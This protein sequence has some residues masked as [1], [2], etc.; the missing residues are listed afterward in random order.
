MSIFN[1]FSLCGGLAFFLFGMRIMSTG[2]EKMAG[3]RLESTLKTM[4]ASPL[5]SMVLGAGITVAIQS[6]SALTVM[7]VGLVNS[8]IMQLRQTVSVI[9]G[10]NIGTTLTA[11][12]LSLAGIESDNFFIKML[13]PTSFSPLVALVGI[14]LIM[15]SKSDKKKDIGS[16][17]VGFAILM[18][19]MSEMSSS[20]S[21]LADIPEFAQVLT[22]FDNPLMG[23]LI[24]AVVT[25]I[26]QASA[27]SV[28]MLQAL[29]MTGSISIGMAVPIIMGQNIGTCVTAMISSVGTNRNAK[30]VAAVHIFFNIIGTAIFL[31]LFMLYTNFVNPMIADL[32]ITP[33]GIAAAHSAFNV[34]A[35]IVLFPFGRLLE[36]LACLV[37]RDKKNKTE[38]VLIDDRL[39]VTPSIAI[40]ECRSVAVDMARK[41]KD[42]LLDAVSLLHDYTPEGEERIRAGEDET[43]HYEDVLGAFLVKLSAKELTAENSSEVAKL[44]HIIGDIER[45]GDHALN[46]AGAAR[47]RFEKN[48]EFS[49]AATADL[50]V[51]ES[52]LDEI[53]TLTVEAMEAED[54]EKAKLIE[55]LEDVIDQLNFDIKARHISRLQTGECTVLLGFILSDILTNLERVSDHCSNIAVCMLQEN[56]AAMSGHDYMVRVKTKDSDFAE[57][58]RK[59]SEK[60]ELGAP[61][62]APQIS[63]EDAAIMRTNL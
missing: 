8:G 45:I 23:V 58:L 5:R 52:A 14:I 56:D 27:A 15:A 36:K 49:A 11:W 25:G 61:V 4:T 31:T 35:T 60:Y 39:L 57:E 47:E 12:L 21:G 41:A 24:G 10:S 37:V 53:L 22:M 16:I 28:G 48:A 34:L 18:Y 1:L 51:M 19:G 6:S 20:V 62:T 3:S 13:K 63:D 59:Y 7:L 29:A 42:T 26:I 30:R 40:S 9:M 38:E 2:L 50:Q 46:L 32:P 33:V 54:M 17:M 44:L 55:P 43:D